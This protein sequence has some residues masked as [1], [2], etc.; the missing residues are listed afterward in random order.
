MQIKKNHCKNINKTSMPK[1][2]IKQSQADKTHTLKTTIPNF[3][4]N[5]TGIN[6]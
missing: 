1:R 3:F 4:E 5:H 2:T 6:K